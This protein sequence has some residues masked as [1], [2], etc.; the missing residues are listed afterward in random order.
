MELYY[1][2]SHSRGTDISGDMNL[3]GIKINLPNTSFTDLN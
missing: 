2:E 3:T 1:L